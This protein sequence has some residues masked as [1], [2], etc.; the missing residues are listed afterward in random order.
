LAL[1]RKICAKERRP[2]AAQ[3]SRP[4]ARIAAAPGAVKKRFDPFA[5]VADMLFE[6]F[7]VPGL[8]HYS[9][10]VGCEG[11][12][13][14]AIVDPE[15]DSGRY[16]AFARA[17]GMRITHVLETH[18]HADFA[19]GARELAARAGAELALVPASADQGGPDP[20]HRPRRGIAR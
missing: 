17:R 14:L 7:E 5:I 9:Y 8:A 20:L 13:V 10:A 1:L 15:R 2:L 3:V 6:R 12:G 11:A 18:I 4:A 19:S 16:L